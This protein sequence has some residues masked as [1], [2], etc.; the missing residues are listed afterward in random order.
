MV[1]QRD[2]QVDGWHGTY[3]DRFK[4]KRIIQVRLERELIVARGPGI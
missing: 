3:I 1:I 4:T 2:G